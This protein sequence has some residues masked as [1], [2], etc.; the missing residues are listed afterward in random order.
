MKRITFVLLVLACLAG[1]FQL[2]QR[3]K[4]HPSVSLVSMHVNERT[5]F[6][7]GVRLTIRI[8]NDSPEPLVVN[9]AAH[10][11]AINGL[12]VGKALDSGRFE[13][14]RLGSV[15]RDLRIN[16]SSMRDLNLLQTYLDSGQIEYK[17]GSVLYGRTTAEDIPL[18]KSEVIDL[19]QTPGIFGGPRPT[20][21]IVDPDEFRLADPE[22]IPSG[23]L[24]Q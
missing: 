4:A 20:G 14:P 3:R 8:D 23:D 18:S 5:L 13:V 19:R 7:Y 6:E 15:T 10:S 22:T 12:Y 2:A 17:M 1:C 21:R 16:M 24:A 11:V 9:G